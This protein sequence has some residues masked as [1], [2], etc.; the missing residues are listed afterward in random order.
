MVNPGL[1]IIR[2]DDR[3]PLQ[4]DLASLLYDS[5]ADIPEMVREELMSEYL[6]ELEKIHQFDRNEF[7]QY[8]YGYVLIRMMQAMGA[9]GFRGFLRKERGI[10]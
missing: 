5:K 4:Y 2:E 8:F 6:D 1:L 7:C 10:F 3:G 9:Y